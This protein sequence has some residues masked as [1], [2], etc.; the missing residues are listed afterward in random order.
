[1]TAGGSDLYLGSGSAGPITSSTVSGL[2][3]N[4]STVYVRLWWQINGAWLF[5]DYSYTAF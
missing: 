1:M 2:P 5:G 4:G 3:V